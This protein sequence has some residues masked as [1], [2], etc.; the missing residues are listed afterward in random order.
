[1]K[2]FFEKILL[3]N[4]FKK[5]NCDEKECSKN[6]EFFEQKN[7]AMKIMARKNYDKN[8]DKKNCDNNIIC[9]KKSYKT[10]I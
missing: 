1:M 3:T 6:V 8:C 2:Y 5:K 7:T 4:K 9:D 10:F